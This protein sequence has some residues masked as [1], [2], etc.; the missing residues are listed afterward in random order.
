[1][2]I[3][4]GAAS[5]LLGGG[6]L[7]FMQFLITRH[8]NKHDKFKGVYEAIEGL[9]KQIKS[10][11]DKADERNA[12]NSRVRILRFADEMMEG[13]RHSKDSWDQV[14]GSDVTDYE[15][16]C[17]THPDFKNSQT[18]ATVEYLKKNYIERLE[19]HDFL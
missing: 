10:V 2:E 6:M 8:D 1:M 3:L 11:S 13:K 17:A 5:L 4:Y 15:N 18:A 16:Y 14:M 19:K 9:S 7:A 12:V